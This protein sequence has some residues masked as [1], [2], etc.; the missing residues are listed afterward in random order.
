[1]VKA[2]TK[3]KI[4]PPTK[5]IPTHV[6]E[7]P[8]SSKQSSTDETKNIQFKVTPD[9]HIEIKSYAAERGLSLKEFFL[10]LYENERMK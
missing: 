10:S 6:T 3:I 5:Q 9:K 8:A 2:M 1:M 4:A 7:S